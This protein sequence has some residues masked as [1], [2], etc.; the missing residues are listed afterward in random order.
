MTELEG[1]ADQQIII[2][3]MHD[4]QQIHCLALSHFSLLNDLGYKSM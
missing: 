4:S 3:Q 1:H 2:S